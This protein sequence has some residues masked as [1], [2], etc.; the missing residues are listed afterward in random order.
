MAIKEKN[1]FLMKSNNTELR[2]LEISYLANFAK[3]N[4]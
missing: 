4:L 2:L 3:I 1:N